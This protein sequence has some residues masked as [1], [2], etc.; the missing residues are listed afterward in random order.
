MKEQSL[1]F[2][3]VAIGIIIMAFSLS[4]V[5]LLFTNKT[6]PYEVFKPTVSAPAPSYTA[7]ELEADPGLATKLQ[8]EMFGSI[9]QKE[10]GKSLNLGATLFFMYFV[11]TFGY[12]LSLIGVQL[13]RPIKVTVRGKSGENEART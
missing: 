3:L 13:A 10:M 12:R 1:G 4:Q 8:S 2:L 7:K 11:M 6:T 9:L 5:Y